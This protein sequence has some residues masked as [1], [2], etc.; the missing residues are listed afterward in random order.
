MIFVFKLWEEKLVLV[1]KEI[2]VVM[3]FFKV[4]DEKVKELIC[5]VKENMKKVWI[6]N[7]CVFNISESCDLFYNVK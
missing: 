6:L 1:K 7:K 3:K 2:K 4:I 5:I